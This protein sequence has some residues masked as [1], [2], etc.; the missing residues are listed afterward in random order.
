MSQR[1]SSRDAGGMLEFLF[2]FVIQRT[3]PG[4]PQQELDVFSAFISVLQA[5]KPCFFHK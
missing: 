4:L 1:E 3:N 5:V 2:D